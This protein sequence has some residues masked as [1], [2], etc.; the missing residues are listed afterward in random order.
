M[1]TQQVA[2]RAPKTTDL[3]REF[4]GDRSAAGSPEVMIAFLDGA[5]RHPVVQGIRAAM[6]SPLLDRAAPRTDVA[7]L[8]AACGLGAETRHLAQLLPGRLVVGLDHNQQLLDIASARATATD[9]G[10]VTGDARPEIEWICADVRA[11]GLP[12]ASV[13]ATRIERGLIYLDDPE[14]AVAEFVRVLAPGGVLV[15][16]ELDYGGL[17]LPIGSASPALMREVNTVME[18]S[19]PAPWAGRQ[20]ARWMADAGLTEITTTPMNIAAGPAVAD[21]IVADTVRTAV[22]EG[23]LGADALEWLASIA[24]E[25]PAL[26]AIT[27]VGFLATAVK[28]AR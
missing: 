18:A 8:D 5:D 9:G 15:A 2:E 10:H 23:R 6:R 13:A 19:L 7:L 21:R 25:P 14:A 26:P 1:S 4:R 24:L 3:H 16:Y 20:L 22:A 11:T 12:D 17:V 27:V 28:P